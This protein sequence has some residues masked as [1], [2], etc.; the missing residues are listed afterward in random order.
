MSN[1]C[2][3]DRVVVIGKRLTGAIDWLAPSRPFNPPGSQLVR[4]RLDRARPRRNVIVTCVRD[5]MRVYEEAPVEH[6]DPE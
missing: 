2:I 5:L 6:G 1:W 4:V 3:G